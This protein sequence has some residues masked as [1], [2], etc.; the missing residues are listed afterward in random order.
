MR[1]KGKAN[2]ADIGVGVC[3]RPPNRDEEVDEIFCKQLGEV[4][5]WLALVLAV[6]F[7]LPDACWKYSP[8]ERKQSRRFLERVEDD[9]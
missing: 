7:N 3:S 1:I 4:S 5:R 2:K 8:G 6:D 9:R